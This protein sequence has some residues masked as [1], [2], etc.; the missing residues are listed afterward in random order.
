VEVIVL[1]SPAQV[2]LRA[3]G[4]VARLLRRNPAAV[5][6]LP[7]GNTPR[8]LYAELGRL[9]GA[10]GLS[11]S[12]ASGFALDEYVGI[13]TD[14]AGAFR[15][16]LEETFIRHVDLPP[17]RV[18]FPDGR[19]DDLPAACARYEAEIAAA[20]GLDLVILGLGADGHIAFNEPTSSFG[21][22]TRIKTLTHET[23]AANQDAFGAEPVP[24]HAI[25]VGIAT[26]LEARRC[27]LLAF[28]AAKAPAVVQMIEGPL[29]A[30]VPASALQLHP[31]A[32]ILVDESAAARLSLRSYY[33]AVAAAKPDWQRED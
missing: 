7:T 23:R 21:S 14:H 10:A 4:M 27:L 28:G 17:E 2:C 1:A 25:T 33:D 12:R 3:A 22:R 29:T 13:A 32:T 30:R 18:H 31:H 9:H 20:G 19:A 6:G 11:F 24:R 16:Y 5:L 26:I 8:A 15:R